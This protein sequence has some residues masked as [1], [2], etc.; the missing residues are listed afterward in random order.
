MCKE[1]LTT[2]RW[3]YVVP[4]AYDRREAPRRSMQRHSQ[5]TEPTIT[6]LG[7]WLVYAISG[8][9]ASMYK[10]TQQDYVGYCRCVQLGTPYSLVPRRYSEPGNEATCTPD[11]AQIAL[12]SA[13]SPIVCSTPGGP[14]G[15]SG[16]T[17][18][19]G[20][21]GRMRYVYKVNKRKRT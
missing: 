19:G 18:P 21:T 11:I 5:S 3:L 20:P 16:P 7:R 9:P 15:P 1:L 2:A 14:G 12:C 8:L 6:L 17:G 10:A 13:N 4:G